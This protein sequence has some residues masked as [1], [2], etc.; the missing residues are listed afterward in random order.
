[1]QDLQVREKFRQAIAP[2]VGT[3]VKGGV[4]IHT[5]SASGDRPAGMSFRGAIRKDT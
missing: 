2:G 5:E 4:W 1:M 3:E